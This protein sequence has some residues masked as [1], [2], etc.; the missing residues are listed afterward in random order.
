M[1]FSRSSESYSQ[2][3]FQV[4]S[5]VSLA[6]PTSVGKVGVSACANVSK[7]ESSKARDMST[8]DKLFIRGGSRETSSKLQQDISKELIQQFMNEAADTHSSVQYTFRAI[9]EV[10]QSRFPS[11]S[12]NY[13][14]GLNLQYYYLGFLNY[15]CRYVEGGE[16]NNKVQIQKFDYGKGSNDKYPEFECSLAKEGCHSDDDCHYKP[17][18]CSCR[19][20]TC[21]HYKTEEQDTGASKETAYPNTGEDWGWQ[22]CDWKVAGS[23]CACYNKHLGW[24]K[25]VWSLPSKD[26]VARKSAANHGARLK[27]KDPG[28]GQS[29][30]KEVLL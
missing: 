4:K 25:V 10:L 26:Y 16:G 23:W 30:R 12:A 1:S 14:R 3:Q 11:G 29:K 8:T 13:I 21:V 15:G 6:G 9:W 28:H 20:P 7:S 2:R 22:G 27:A 19:G 5:C 17:I 18:W 24:R